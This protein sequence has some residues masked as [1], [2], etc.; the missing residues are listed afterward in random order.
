[1]LY[2]YQRRNSRVSLF[3]NTYVLFDPPG[4]I[5]KRDIDIES[6]QNVSVRNSPSIIA[7][8]VESKSKTIPERINSQRANLNN[9]V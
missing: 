2:L 7:S 1:M 5:V 9:L 8:F 6:V 4:T 3:L